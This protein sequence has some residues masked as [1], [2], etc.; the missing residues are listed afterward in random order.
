MKKII[1][2]TI[3]FLNTILHA[4]EVFEYNLI[5]DFKFKVYSED[6]N[7]FYKISKKEEFTQNTPENVALSSFF[8]YSNDIASK[9][10]LNKKKYAP[11]NDTDFDLIKK[12]EKE[13]AYIKLLHKSN[14][15]FGDKD[16]AYI[17]FIANVKDIPYSFPTV[18]SLIKKGS[19]WYLFQRPNQEKL[20][21]SLM[22]LKPCVLSN[23]IE[24]VSSDNDIN[25][26]I[27]K[28]KSNTGDL[29]F[30]KVFDELVLIQKNENLSSKLT[31]T[32]NSNCSGVNFKSNV[33][34]KNI[35]TGIFKNVT[36]NEFKEQDQKLISKIRKNNDSIV[37]RNKLDLNF[38]DK[39]FAMIKYDIIR[40]DGSV[41]KENKRLDSNLIEGPVKELFFLYEKLDPKIFDELSPRMTKKAIMDTKL[42]KKTRGVY[43]VLNI[44]KLYSLFQEE[45]E[46]FKK[47]LIN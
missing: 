7:K 15:K 43:D 32:Q 30:T 44:S 36:I 34:G 20:T 29:D 46:L 12:T 33:N 2:F 27:L 47:Y 8:A 42:Y 45:K 13:N 40:P 9:L 28:T 4:Q 18:L 16:M 1:F 3:L 17:M 21:K 38:S 25:N 5:K 35:I 11:R 19:K 26:L 23:L 31:M 10:Y 14:Y 22:M 39:K 6:E 41:V 24:G 37:L